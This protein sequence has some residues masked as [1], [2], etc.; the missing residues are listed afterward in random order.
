VWVTHLADAFINSEK[1]AHAEQHQ[2]DNERPE[3]ALSLMPKRMLFVSFAHGTL[4]A[5]EE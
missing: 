4:C 1:A 2:G 5:Q 3:I